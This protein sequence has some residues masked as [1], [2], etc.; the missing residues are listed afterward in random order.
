MKTGVGIGFVSSFTPSH[1]FRLIS[2]AV[3]QTEQVT[4]LS[5]LDPK[6]LIKTAVIRRS[7]SETGSNADDDTI[8]SLSPECKRIRS[9]SWIASTDLVPHTD[10]SS[11]PH[12]SRIRA[13]LL[14]GRKCTGK[15]VITQKYSMVR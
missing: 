10:S 5:I 6:V 15:T 8:E 2:K 12:N 14:P 1:K 9:R 13:H 7:R 4:V 11:L 3:L